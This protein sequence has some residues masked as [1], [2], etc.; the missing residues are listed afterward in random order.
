MPDVNLAEKV[1]VDDG[2]DEAN[3]TTDE[4]YHVRGD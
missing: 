4:N 3:Y 2:V 1:G